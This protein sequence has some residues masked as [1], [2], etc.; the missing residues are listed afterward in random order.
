MAHVRITEIKDNGI[1]YFEISDPYFEVTVSNFGCRVLSIYTIDKDRHM[2]DVLLGNEN[3][4]GA[5][6]GRYMGAVCGRVCNRIEKGQFL[7][8][9]KEYHL[10]V[11]NGP[12]HL[13]GGLE[14]FDRKVFHW[15]VI[16]DGVTFSYMSPNGEEGYPGNL[17]LNVTYTVKDNTLCAHYRAVAD[18]DTLV[19]I[20]NHMYFN[21]SGGA[22]PA[23]EH[24][25]EVDADTYMPVD[26]N[27]LTLGEEADVTGTPFD[28]RSA[29]MI[30]QSIGADNEQ[31]RNA[32]GYDHAYLLN[33]QDAQVVL[34]DPISHR[35]LT[36]TTTLPAVHVYTG[37]YLESDVPGKN[38]TMYKNYD[39]IALETE[40]VP[41]SINTERADD[42]ILRQ[43]EVYETETLYKFEAVR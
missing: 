1:M 29:H 23:S 19:N 12:N 32:H 26:E 15:E 25:L 5:S 7:L 35:R 14:G 21:L 16:K 9:D 39:G 18:E 20:T 34:T 2:E 4:E 22:R 3:P 36:V 33:G 40:Y 31:L 17:L 28:F 41:N 10:A 37:N 30:S 8:N 42:V 24:I 11:N 6:D 13:H 27:G 38:G 43:G